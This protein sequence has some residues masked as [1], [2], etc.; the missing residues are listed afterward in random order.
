MDLA[1]FLFGTDKLESDLFGRI[2][3]GSRM[4]LAIELFGVTLSLHD[5]C[6]RPAAPGS[7][8]RP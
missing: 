5:P 7:A 8:P 3:Y 1:A 6:R 2:V 4:S